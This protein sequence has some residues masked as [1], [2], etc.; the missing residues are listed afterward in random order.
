[1][2]SEY[3]KMMASITMSN[4]DWLA[5]EMF[6]LLTTRYREKERDGWREMANETNEH[7]IK[8]W[9]NAEKNADFWQKEIEAVNRVMACIAAR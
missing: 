4:D 6:L 7:G 5:L 1:M 2:K 9:H 8:V 3:G